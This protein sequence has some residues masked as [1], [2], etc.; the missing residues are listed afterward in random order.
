MA[1]S[2]PEQLARETIDAM[3][4]VAGWAIQDIA[5]LNLSASRGVAVREMQSYGGPADYILFVDGKALGVV[6]AMKEGT[7]LSA[8]VGQPR[9]VGGRTL[10]ACERI[11]CSGALGPSCQCASPS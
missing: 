3:L 1:A 8:V 2:T 4:A 11:G 10:T 5:T 9:P 7:T 6:E